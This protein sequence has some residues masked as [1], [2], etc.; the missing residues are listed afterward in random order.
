MIFVGII[1]VITLNSCGVNVASV[2]NLN[3]NATQVQLNSNNFQIVDKVSG[4]AEVQYVLI[5]GGMNKKKLYENAYAAM[6]ENANLESGSKALIN[7]VTENHI[8]GIP[9]FSYKRTVT[10]SSHV[11]EFNR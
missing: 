7:I 8:G 11:I 10:V 2:Y 4:S 6:V 1:M 5:F 3:Q 9:P